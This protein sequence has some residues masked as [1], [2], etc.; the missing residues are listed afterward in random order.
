MES[1]KHGRP[2][3]TLAPVSVSQSGATMSDSETGSAKFSGP[4]TARPTT[5]VGSAD[6]TEPED[7]DIK[8]SDKHD[9][10]LVIMCRICVDSTKIDKAVGLQNS[11]VSGSSS[12]KLETSK[13]H[14]QSNNHIRVKAIIAAAENPNT[15]PA[16]KIV[17]D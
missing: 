6:S 7:H 10:R 2:W 14:E 12:F 16:Y 4:T 3:L 8:L 13:L 17:C 1:W 5:S 9:K 11:F 15:A